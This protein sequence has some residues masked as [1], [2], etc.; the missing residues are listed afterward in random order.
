MIPQP[1]R[2]IVAALLAVVLFS[3]TTAL[4]CGPFMLEAVFVHTVHPAYPLERFAS[5]RI[6]VLQP[7]YARSY[8]VVAYRHLAGAPLTSAEQEALTELWN[9]RLDFE[10]RSDED[11]TKA[12]SEARQ[13]V[14]GGESLVISPYRSRAKP[15][16]YQSYL[17]C[18]KDAFD[19]AAATLNDR[20][21]K[22]GA[23]NQAVKTWIAAQ[24]DVFRDCGGDNVIP[25]E[26]PADADA[27]M[28][29][30]RAYQI[31]AAH[32][33][34][35][36]F[37]EAK[38]G[39]EAI[40]ADAHSPWQRNAVYLIAR[41]HARKGSLG[42]SEQRAESLGAAEAQLR[43]ILADKNLSSLHAASTR[44]LNLVRL[45][46]HPRERLRELA[47]VLAD[48]EPN[49]NLKQD[50]IDYTVL[51]DLYLEEDEEEEAPATS[52]TGE[53]P[54]DPK[55]DNPTAPKTESAAAPEREELSV[56]RAEDL[57]DWIVTF[58]GADKADEHALERWQATHSGPWLIAALTH[59]EGK[60]P[61]AS[62]LISEALKVNTTS[63]A[64]PSARFHATR[65]LMEQGKND[66]ARRL[67]NQSLKTERASFDESSLNLL[68]GKRMLLAQSLPEFLADAARVPAALSWNDDGRE[69]PANESWLGE[70]RQHYKG[71]PFFDY[72]AGH[73]FNE[74]L[75]LSVLKEAVKSD[76]LPPGPRLDLAQAVWLRAALLG[77]AKTADELTPI[78]TS[79]VPELKP[80]LDS[81]RATVQPDEK[82]F[83]AIYAWLKFPGLEPVVDI[84]FGREAKLNEQDSYRDNWWCRSYITPAYPEESREVVYFTATP[85]PPPPFLSP[86]EVKKGESEVAA[87]RAL[88]TAPNYISREVIAWANRRPADPRVPEALHLAVR[89]TRYGCTDKETVRWS[90][91]AFDVLHKKYPTSPWAKKT[92]YWFKD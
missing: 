54:A 18:Q 72:D 92:P 48:K 24:D 32:F 1:L 13:K 50:L 65:L 30:D 12:W 71:K 56:P 75:P 4:A 73:A 55:P 91:A 3:S 64:F 79:L 85:G 66:D 51:L 16:E 8:L 27:L 25:A 36:N 40:A 20:V 44:L 6:G 33:Y 17:N 26:L 77:D 31:A 5:G 63:A 47:K 81:Y 88:G 34:S 2:T 52:P 67:L 83:A 86:A 22:Y 19:T 9:E 69:V 7:T 80:L 70:E 46:L 82:K 38:K 53:N 68:T 74:Q 23:D 10:S 90:K 58:Q 41:A 59:A 14:I 76:V 78:L 37:D 15:N 45:R 43:K 35:T 89:T 39:F 28:R 61:K 60:D 11:I 84:G 42:T 62:E 21:A 57:S 87:L 49:P 29:A